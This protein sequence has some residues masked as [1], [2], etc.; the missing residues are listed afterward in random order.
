[1][2]PE[3]ISPLS[4]RSRYHAERRA[5][6]GMRIVFVSTGKVWRG[7]EEQERLLVH[8]LTQ[9]GHR[10]SILARWGGAYAQRMSREGARVVTFGGRGI[11][12]AAWWTIRRHLVR[13]RPD[14]VHY[15]DPQAMVA[16]GLAGI[17]LGP[18]RLSNPCRIGVRRVDFP[19]R[20]PMAYR[21]FCDR[22]ICVSEG[23][24]EVALRSRLPSQ[25]LE[26]V[27]DGVDPNRVVTGDRER[28]RR[29]LGVR[30]DEQVL[31]VVAALTDHKGH[32]YLLDALPDV[33]RRFPGVRLFL[34]GDGELRGTLERQVAALG[35]AARVTLLGF[36]ADIPDLLRAAD[37]F[38]LPSKMEGMGSTLLD[39]MFARLPIVTTGAGGIPEVVGARPGEPCETAW[40]VPP[41][42]SAAL[43][44]A[45]RDALGAEEVR[46]RRAEMA[47][48]RAHRC[49]TADVMVE[50][51]LAVFRAALDS[52]I[53]RA[54]FPAGDRPCQP[55]CS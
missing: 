12:P 31:L 19:V 55:G 2:M 13:E 15:D 49:F 44:A 54:M 32:H 16:A 36:R 45:I 47:L 23:V 41:C 9:R 37:L 7:G 43:A 22:V 40:I 24:R 29:S 27:P 1:M 18:S 52:R 46:R 20:S 10:C 8:G 48:E 35:L 51:T 33:V 34:A 42:D 11:S 25:L 6:L 50:R 30:N 5:A 21:Q 28:G 53:N 38:V 14:V 39:A 17:G 3:W 4:V 26:V